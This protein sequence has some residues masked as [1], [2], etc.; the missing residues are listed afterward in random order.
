MAFISLPCVTSYDKVDFK[1][2]TGWHMIQTDQR[3]YK[4][5]VEYSQMFT[6]GHNR[7]S[8]PDKINSLVSNIYDSLF[9]KTIVKLKLIYVRML[10]SKSNVQ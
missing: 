4:N 8:T 3:M 5:L 2:T 7:V 6:A 1:H 10:L 9:S